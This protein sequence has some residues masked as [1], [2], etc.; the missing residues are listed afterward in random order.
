MLSHLEKDIPL[1]N[2]LYKKY[3]VY[4]SFLVHLIMYVLIFLKFFLKEKRNSVRVKG[5]SQIIPLRH[6]QSPGC[7][8]TPL[9]KWGPGIYFKKSENFWWY[10]LEV[11]LYTGPTQFF[12]DIIYEYSQNTASH[13]VCSELSPPTTA[14]NFNGS[15]LDCFRLRRYVEPRQL[16]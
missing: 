14:K 9:H 7:T 15:V 10:H 4:A 8:L 1:R 16:L 6:R 12:T 2:T 5:H 3:W 13:A 11:L